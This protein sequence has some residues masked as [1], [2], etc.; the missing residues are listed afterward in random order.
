[1]SARIRWLCLAA[2][3]VCAMAAGSPA[4][5]QEKDVVWALSQAPADACVVSV[6]RSV[7]E[8]ETALKAYV[9][10]EGEDI[11]MVKPLEAGLP[12]GALDT[13]GPL[14]AILLPNG[15]GVELVTMLRIKDESK[16][17]GEAA[18]GNII[19][20][21]EVY[22]LKM[23]P[24]AATSPDADA[25]KALAAA[26]AR[27]AGLA[28]RRGDIG[29]H[30]A[31][32]SVNPKSLA[33]VAKAA[34]EAEAQQG[35]GAQGPP[36]MAKD[37]LTWMISLLGDVRSM[38]AVLDVKPETASLVAD[39][40]LAENTPLAAVAAASLPIESYK[41][42][43]P[44]SERLVV[45]GWMRLDWAKAAAP[46]KVIVKPLLDIMTAKADEAARK[47]IADMWTMYDQWVGVMGTDVALVM[48][49]A[50][51]GQGMYRMTETVAI[52]DPVE[53]GKLKSKMMAATKDLMKSMMGQ[54][55]GMPGGPLM[56]MDMDFKEAAETIE[57]VAVDVMK[58]KMEM[59]LPPDAPPEAKAQL[60]AMMDA[61]YGPEGMTMRMALVDKMAVFTIGDA[62]TMAR[63]IKAAR[64]QAPDLSANPK[65]AA[66]V[67]RLPTGVC[68]GGVVSF[69]NLMY[70][71]MSMT[72]R[73]LS[74]TMPSEIQEA[75]RKANLP[76]LEAPPAADL[77]IVS[78]S[79]KGG[80]FH[81]ELSVPQA[82]VRNAVHVVK[83]AS[84]RIM[85]IVQQ[86]QKMMQE[87]MQQQQQGAPGAAPGAAPA[88]GTPESAA[89]VPAA[90]TTGKK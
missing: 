71:T 68:A 1:M 3:L 74:Q 42:G 51:P 79:V 64:G 78:G 90:P 10:P 75:A 61:T 54:M 2:A 80:A 45:A 66:A 13:A 31:W 20:I 62:D 85:W 67:G 59:Q 84:E 5:A 40:Q 8:L 52:K 28:D 57:G 50:L 53:Y 29:A 25:L 73:M 76:P 39:V 60:K 6:I 88:P 37:V 65:V 58:M 87:R 44:M 43:L 56:K 4:S 17:T 38:T 32:A 26:T 70:M 36:A 18:E 16:L 77:S 9:G 48:E 12:P 27:L 30:L 24:W 46:M 72:D 82:D 33:A 69:A 23:A 63:S 41:G 89:P 15:P 35:P 47:G 7:Q 49:P 22:V 11:E 55:G 81:V 21:G 86:Q 19:K 14:V 83:S 34:I